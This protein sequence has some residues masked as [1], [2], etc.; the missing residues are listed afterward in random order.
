MTSKI[1]A[2]KTWN[3]THNGAMRFKADTGFVV[4]AGTNAVWRPTQAAAEKFA[5]A[6]EPL[7]DEQISLSL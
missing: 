2:V 7:T 5:K 4:I 1:V 3:E 6:V